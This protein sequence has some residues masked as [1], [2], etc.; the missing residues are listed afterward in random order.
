M[1]WGKIT[2]GVAKTTDDTGLD[3][4]HVVVANEHGDATF[5]VYPFGVGGPM[6]EGH[7]DW[8]VSLFNDVLGLDAERGE[9]DTA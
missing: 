5:A 7:A 4:L 3:W 9:V 1:K 6:A 2:V 8:L